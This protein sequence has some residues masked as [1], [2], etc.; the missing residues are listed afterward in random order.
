VGLV[1]VRC[2]VLADAFF[3]RHDIH[4]L[5]TLFIHPMTSTPSSQKPCKPPQP[6]AWSEEGT[7]YTNSLIGVLSDDLGWE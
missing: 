5:P 7:Q 3:M 4:S 2:V 6:A 1:L